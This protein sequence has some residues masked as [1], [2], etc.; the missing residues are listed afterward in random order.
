MPSVQFASIVLAAV[1]SIVLEITALK[2]AW[3]SVPSER[4]PAWIVGFSTVIVVGLVGLSC[5]GVDLVRWGGDQLVCPVGLESWPQIVFDTI[6][7]VAMT[8][9]G[10][11]ATYTMVGSKISTRKENLG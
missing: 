8:S 9:I 10:M 1:L 4:K 7:T 5:V 6:M 2:T 3:N 11:F